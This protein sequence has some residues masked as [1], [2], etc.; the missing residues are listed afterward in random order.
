MNSTDEV[1]SCTLTETIMK[2][3][4]CKEKEMVWEVLFVMMGDSLEA[5]G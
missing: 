3:K 4:L 1:E 2:E 5:L